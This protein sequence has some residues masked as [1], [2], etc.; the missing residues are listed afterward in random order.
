MST[1][2][3]K[4]IKFIFWKNIRKMWINH[5]NKPFVSDFVDILID[6]QLF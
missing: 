1:L 5:V 4:K 6:L 3:L 2:F